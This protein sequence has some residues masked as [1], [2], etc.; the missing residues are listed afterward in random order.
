M[1]FLAQPRRRLGRQKRVAAQIEEVVVDADAF[2]M[3]NVFPDFCN[4]SFGRC[5]R[6]GQHGIR[7]RVAGIED[8]KGF[9][10]E[11]AAGRERHLLQEKKRRRRHVVRQPVLQ[12]AAQFADRRG[13]RAGVR[14]IS[15][16]DFVST[17]IVAYV[18][19]NLPDRRMLTDSIFDLPKFDTKTTN[20][21]LMVEAAEVFDVSIG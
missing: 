15:R 20:F 11:L 6:R 19:G 14:D 18:H 10:V 8:G 17:R 16:E 1:E 13:M 2:P 3:E 21:Y 4:G 7:R 12:E 9:P 5:P